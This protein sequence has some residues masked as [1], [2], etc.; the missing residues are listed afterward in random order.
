MTIYS[1]DCSL[2]SE[3]SDP[4]LGQLLVDRPSSYVFTAAP[5]P[6]VASPSRCC[7]IDGRCR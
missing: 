3:Q 5:D 1:A 7:P 2:I 4:A 6:D